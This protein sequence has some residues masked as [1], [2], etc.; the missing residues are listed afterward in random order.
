MSLSISS[1]AFCVNKLGP[2]FT[3]NSSVCKKRFPGKKK[4]Y[5]PEKNKGKNTTGEPTYKYERFCVISRKR[6]GPL[7]IKCTC[8]GLLECA[9]VGESFSIGR[10]PL[11]DASWKKEDQSPSVFLKSW[12]KTFVSSNEIIMSYWRKNKEIFFSFKK[13]TVSTAPC[14]KLK[15]KCLWI[16]WE[17]CKY[18][19]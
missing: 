13:P 18:R 2:S 16:T 10:I 11:A 14:K 19:H 6:E 4:K 7:E 17:Y 15:R 9:K 12:T 5:E 8:V 1:R 3:L